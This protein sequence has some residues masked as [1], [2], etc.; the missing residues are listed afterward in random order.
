M[1]GWRAIG[2]LA[3]LLGASGAGIASAQKPNPDIIVNVAAADP[4]MNAARDRAVAELPDFYRHFA[5]PG[6]GEDGFMIKFD[7]I[8][9]ERAEFVWAG[10]IDRSTTPMTAT[11]LNQPEY[12]DGYHIG[13]RVPIAEADIVD[14]S[15]FRGS[16]MQGGYTQRVLLNRIDPAEAARLRA[17][18]GW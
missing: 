9:G 12:V 16:V 6:A 17:Q 3:L 10:E 18:A 2:G 13:Q 4:E 5:N 7:I 1:T 14:W 8:P 11:L 15:Y